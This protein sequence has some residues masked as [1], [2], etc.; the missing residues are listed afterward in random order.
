MVVLKEALP[1]GCCHDVSAH[2]PVVVVVVSGGWLY[3]LVFRYDV[4]CG[5][6]A[7]QPEVD[8]FSSDVFPL[9]VFPQLP[10]VPAS[11]EGLNDCQLCPPD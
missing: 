3:V 1:N 2:P 4:C 9:V 7:P 11:V 8:E 5:C 6:G 10:L